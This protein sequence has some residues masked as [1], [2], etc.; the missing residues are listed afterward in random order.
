MVRH[1]AG[2]IHRRVTT[3]INAEFEPGIQFPV[4]ADHPRRHRSKPWP[5]RVSIQLRYSQ[6]P[7]ST[8]PNAS[9]PATAA[10]ASEPFRRQCDRCVQ[11][12]TSRQTCSHRRGGLQESA[13][14]HPA[15]QDPKDHRL[16]E[17]H[18]RRLLLLSNIGIMNF[19]ADQ[20]HGRQHQTSVFRVVA[21][22]PDDTRSSMAS[23]SWLQPLGY[24]ER[25]R[26]TAP[27][28]VRTL[29]ACRAA[30]NFDRLLREYGFSA[31]R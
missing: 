7:A 21:V 3:P 14:L 13:E 10:T 25:H 5:V 15:Y 31:S 19:H 26:P 9:T 4:R 1:S 27:T 17:Q 16:P 29:P 6:Q 11:Y 2:A 24:Q 18:H 28:V 12:S 20:R 8:W 23:A 22:E 30:T